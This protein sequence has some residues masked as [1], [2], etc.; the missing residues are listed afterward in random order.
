[1]TIR[2]PS[3]LLVVLSVISTAIWSQE[4]KAETAQC[5]AEIARV[6]AALS[7]AQA[8]KGIVG[9]L[10]QSTAAGLH[11]QPTPRTLAQAQIEAQ[12]K[13]ETTLTVARRLE[14]EGKDADCLAALRSV[15]H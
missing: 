8:D 7:K 9:S 6:E 2:K 12:K 1:M 14:M 11:R 4:A 10:P 5:D 3:A 15:A 13:V